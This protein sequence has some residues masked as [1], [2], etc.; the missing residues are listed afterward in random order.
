[1][2]LKREPTLG[3]AATLEA[4]KSEAERANA[5]KSRLLATANH[6]LRQPIWAAGAFLSV[7]ARKLED[8]AQKEV[9]ENAR[10]SLESM[11]N[12]LDQLR[13]ISQLES[14]AV[15]PNPEHILVD[16][17]IERAVSETSQLAEERAL[18]LT[19][20]P[21]GCEIHSDRLLLERLLTIILE[22]TIRHTLDGQVVVA[23]QSDQGAA[24]IVIN[25]PTLELCAELHNTDLEEWFSHACPMEGPRGGGNVGLLVATYIALALGVRIQVEPVGAACRITLNLPLKAPAT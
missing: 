4:A 18:R 10:Q 23:C 21:S 14:G 12:T 3:K 6:D 24:R 20:A 1:M 7:L 22:N 9:C 5:L 2:R 17:V 15:R 25:A 19:L 11:R 13:E 16:A 8:P